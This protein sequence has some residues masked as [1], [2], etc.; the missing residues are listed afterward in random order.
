MPALY[1]DVV[2]ALPP[3]LSN[4][5]AGIPLVIYMN[6][7]MSQELPYAAVTRTPAFKCQFSDASG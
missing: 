4:D 1:G 3:A 5:K 2:C 7:F 6:T